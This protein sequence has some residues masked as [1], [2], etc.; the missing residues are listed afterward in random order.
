MAKFPQVKSWLTV[1][2][3]AASG[4][5]YEHTLAQENGAENSCVLAHLKALVTEAHEDARIRLRRLACNSLA[6]FD[7]QS[8]K[9]P[10]E[11]Y[12][13]RLHLQTLKGYFGEV[14]A[15]V[16]AE[17]YPPFGKDEWE[18]PAYL[19]RFHTVA[20]QQLELLKQVGGPAKVIPGRTGDDCLAFRRCKEGKITAALLCEAKCTA[21]H[22]AQLIN[23]AH[24]KSSMSNP[25]PIDLLQL[26]EILKDSTDPGAVEWVSCL[27]E[28]SLTGGDPHYER[29]DHV[30]YVCGRKPKKNG[31][32][33]IPAD[34]PHAKYT[35]GRKL[36]VVEIQLTDV[37]Q[38]V[39]DTYG[40]Q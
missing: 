28:L 29:V 11:G 20:F 16:F 6:P 14:M 18:V 19:F 23:D 15:G 9:D 10:A 38:L 39:K 30:T 2:A 17:N 31:K 7:R 26:I 12:P 35:G 36:H 24:V 32:S 4:G 40:V 21:D 34:K 33:W 5:L 13:Q 25:L 22:D 3:N 37:E 8:T 1:E 27:Q